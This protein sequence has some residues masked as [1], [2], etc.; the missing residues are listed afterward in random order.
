[1][2]KKKQKQNLQFM[3][4][5]NLLNIFWTY[6]LYYIRIEFIIYFITV[7]VIAANEISSQSSMYTIH[8]CIVNSP[9]S[10]HWMNYIPIPQMTN[11]LYILLY[12]NIFFLWNFPEFFFC[13]FFICLY[14]KF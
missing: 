3:I 8:V 12:L 10:L 14:D 2:K 11:S 9:P 6:P 4:R 13:R 5:A 7:C 1:M